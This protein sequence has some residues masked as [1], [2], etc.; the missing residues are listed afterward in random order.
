M[1]RIVH[2]VNADGVEAFAARG[3]KPPPA[4]LFGDAEEAYRLCVGR[5]ITGDG[6]WRQRLTRSRLS[7]SGRCRNA[8]ELGSGDQ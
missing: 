7:G 2:V 1:D 4:T 3:I 6:A 5:S 8:G